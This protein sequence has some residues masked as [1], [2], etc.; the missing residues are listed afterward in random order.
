MGKQMI[1]QFHLPAEEPKKNFM[2]RAY[3]I[4]KVYVQASDVDSSWMGVLSQLVGTFGL[5]K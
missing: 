1:K 2:S 4:E 5:S 3:D